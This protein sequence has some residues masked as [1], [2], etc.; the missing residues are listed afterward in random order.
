MGI[1]QIRTFIAIELPGTLRQALAD[2]QAQL[3]DLIGRTGDR[4]IRLQWV[5]PESIHVTLKFL[6]DVDA[7]L[8]PKMQASLAGA[9]SS[10]PRFSVE[11]SGL[12][13]FPD[14]QA[15]R[16]LW[17]GMSG[18]GKELAGLAAQVDQALHELGFP[19]ESRPFRPHLTVARIKERSREVGRALTASGV[20]TKAV[21]IGSLAVSS[22]SVMK[23]ELKPSG[24][25]YTRLCEVS[26]KEP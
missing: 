26:L 14:A 21:E 25:V 23:S 17:V 20:M 7:S 6:G 10:Q 19:L 24:A 18:S 15:P 1:E 12:G 13:A 3:R 2:Q 22:V 9:V 11:V 16:V 8:I 5:K 4:S